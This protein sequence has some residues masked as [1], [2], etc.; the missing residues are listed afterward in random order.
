MLS[1]AEYERLQRLDQAS[2]SGPVVDVAGHRAKFFQQYGLFFRFHSRSKVIVLGW[3]NDQ[4]S[5]RAY[6]SK[7]DACRMFQAL[8]NGHPPKDRVGL[9]Q[10]CGERSKSRRG[11]GVLRLVHGKW[12]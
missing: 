2:A 10:E 4:Q 1:A 3:V 12:L 9:M 5:K 8:T 7:S 6:G 11:R